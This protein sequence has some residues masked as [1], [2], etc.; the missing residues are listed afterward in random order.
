MRTVTQNKMIARRQGRKRNS[1]EMFGEQLYNRRQGTA[2][3]G[4]LIAGLKSILTQLGLS[5]K[6][7]QII[8]FLIGNVFVVRQVPIGLGR[9]G[10]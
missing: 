2:R 3:C 1:L 8:F 7:I 4:S 10:A 5:E 9:R 6:S